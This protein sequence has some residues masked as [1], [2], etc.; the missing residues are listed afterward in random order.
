MKTEFLKGLGLNEDQVNSI[1]AE[2]GKDING[3][4]AER[5]TYKTQLDTA[6]A[7][8]KSF[9]GVNITELQGKVTQLTKDLADK[10]TEFQSKLSEMEFQSNLEKTVGS[11]NPR[12][13]KAVMALLDIDS[14]K[15]SKNQNEEIKAALETVKKDNSYLFQET[16]VPQ[17]VSSTPG[18]N[19][20]LDDKKTQANEALRSLFGK[21]Q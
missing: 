8:L 6:T 2:N 1:M 11:Y 9:E 21:E 15:G 12:N 5:D 10:D 18:V 3:I 19:Q 17:V 13:A 20:N 7:T 4:K 16:K 14:L